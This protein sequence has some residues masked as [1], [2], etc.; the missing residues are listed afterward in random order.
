MGRMTRRELEA[1]ASRNQRLPSLNGVDLTDEDLSDL[2]L[3]FADLSHAHVEGADFTGADLRNAILFGVKGSGACLR[4]ADLRNAN[5]TAADLSRADLT[6]ARLDGAELG[7]TDLSGAWGTHLHDVSRSG[8]IAHDSSTQ[9]V[10]LDLFALSEPVTLR[11]G[12]VL[13]FDLVQPAGG[14]RWSILDPPEPVLDP[15]APERRR[16]S[17]ETEDLQR[18]IGEYSTVTMRFRARRPGQLT[19]RIGL[20]RPWE[21]GEHLETVVL[22]VRVLPTPR[23]PAPDPKH[24]GRRK[25]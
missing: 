7:G 4:R 23:S 18:P 1:I 19:L 9:E 14:Y 20:S 25:R 11:V 5:L 6:D 2:D 24:E 13:S 10:R 17:T 15:A 12:D 22:E 8:V 3:R 21:H 16:P